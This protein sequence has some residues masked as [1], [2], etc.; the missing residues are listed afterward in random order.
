MGGVVF[1]VL[2]KKSWHKRENIREA[3]IE[4][5]EAELLGGG[6]SFKAALAR[7]QKRKEKFEERKQVKQG[8]MEKKVT[9]Y[10][11]KEDATM[12]MLRELAQKSGYGA[13]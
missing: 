4:I 1:C 6:D 13:K 11:A 12:A 2:K 10:R 5:G 8:D 7:Q 3:D 9:E